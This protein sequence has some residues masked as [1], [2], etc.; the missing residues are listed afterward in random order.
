V[1]QELAELAAGLLEHVEAQRRLGAELYLTA[2]PAAVEERPAGRAATVA[3]R[4]PE[5]PPARP[6][7][8]AE[9]RELPAA[10]SDPPAALQALAEEASRC[11]KC[12]LCRTRTNVVFGTGSVG[13]ELAFVGE[14]PGRNEDLQ[15][16]PFVGE[17][18]QLLDKIIAAMGLERS[19][20]Y[21]CNMVKCR[22]PSNRQPSPDEIA[23]CEPFLI[24][25]LDLV[26]PKVIVA[27]GSVAAQAL[28]RTEESIGRLRGKFFR[29]HDIEVMP[30]YHPAYLLR[31]P[32]AK[33]VVWEDMQ[34]VQEKLGI[35]PGSYAERGPY[36][37]PG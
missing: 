17:A 27:L 24:E 33:R 16:E 30:T 4:R 34:K 36:K 18:G 26:R 8:E 9:D 23:A 15:G 11:V 14:A 31:T 3:E 29:Y 35:P 7:R 12:R 21:I 25:Q 32:Q 1:R 6:S 37:R 13:A 19:E 10:P 5:R 28:L 20:V 2:A 22:P